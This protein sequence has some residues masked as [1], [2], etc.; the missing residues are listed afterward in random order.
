MESTV[1]KTQT[2]KSVE[3]DTVIQQVN[4]D[5]EQND[6]L[7]EF[8][9]LLRT[10]QTNMRPGDKDL[11][12]KA[13]VMA[14]DAHATVRRKSGELYIFHPV[15]VAQ[16]VAGEIGLGTT[17]VICALLH[18]VVED[19]E[20]TLE[21]IEKAFGKNI[22]R[23]V[24]GLTKIK[25]IKGV[26]KKS[27]DYVAQQ[28]ENLK[29]ILLTLSEDVR[30]ILVKVAD[31]L[32]NMRTMSSMP[33]HKQVRIASETLYIYAPLAHR[34]GLY[35]IKTELEDLSLRYS[36][37]EIFQEIQTK[38]VQS[39]RERDKFI[40]DFIG[41][42][43]T[44]F[45]ERGV[46]KFKIYGRSKSIHSIWNKIR[47]KKVDFEE[48]YDLFAIRIVIDCP[49]D[50]EKEVCWKVYS[51]I[52][53]LYRPIVE[54]LR[55]WISNPRSNGYESLHT[56][57]IGSNGKP[58]E[59]QI[60]SKRM[61]EVA[62]KGLAAHW[63]YKGGQ[64]SGRELDRWLEQVREVLENNDGDA[65][66]FLN[67]FKQSFYEKE[68]YISTPKGDLK[69]MRGGSTV[70]DFAYEIHTEIG[71][72][73]IGAKIGG[74]LQPISHKLSNGDRVEILTSKKQK[75]SN[76]WLEFAVTPKARSSIK[77]NLK[78]EKRQIADDGK[79]VFERKMKSLFKTQVTPDLINQL[80]TYFKQDDSLNFFYNI[81]TGNF[82]LKQ[83]KNLTIVG[84]KVQ[85]L[86]ERKPIAIDN[87]TDFD[88]NT[89]VDLMLF[90]GLDNVDY[91]ISPCCKP[92]AGDPVFGFI[93]ISNGIKIHRE[94][95]PNAKDLRLKYP[96]RIVKTKWTTDNGSPAFLTGL[97]ITGIDDIGLVNKI[98][99]V[100]SKKIGVNMR[101]LSFDTKD[102]VF[103]GNIKV[104]VGSNA[105]LK[106]LIKELKAVDGVHDVRK[107]DA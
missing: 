90:G 34:L 58:V 43:K 42:L 12:T 2:V 91:T 85:N 70:L 30:V 74:K 7:N 49:E 36:N 107:H 98:T 76:D 55:D 105:E 29:K 87:N 82:D 35:I 1:P 56:T 96:Y 48:V 13:F 18:D 81:A 71:R 32:H 75:P 52:S 66:D 11:I 24:D 73:C 79:M 102:D 97:R 41:P 33:A 21:D 60:R 57:V 14:R 20:V 28:A 68:V 17:S 99:S 53:D 78:T 50:K 23:I 39:K 6:L 89:E 77:S 88:V 80:V 31:R 3:S 61:D 51:I 45:K 9:T 84:G 93:T 4:L 15:A 94:Q 106:R 86:V 44:L 26:T 22:S 104:F 69:T 8:K 54:R 103:E 64:G 10:C 40:K 62:E 37:P 59:V 83:L 27:K 47:K 72:K 5:R 63:K 38:L 92:K 67:D 101:S 16:I 46:E 25:I 95:C 19:T 100:I 65:I